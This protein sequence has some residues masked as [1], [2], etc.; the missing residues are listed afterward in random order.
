MFLVYCRCPAVVAFGV[1]LIRMHGSTLTG[2][3]QSIIL[4]VRKYCAHTFTYIR[5][6]V[7]G[8]GYWCLIWMGRLSPAHGPQDSVSAGVLNMG[9]KILHFTSNTWKRGGRFKILHCP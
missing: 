5:G 3:P 2:Q 4:Y 1:V 8:G 7:G 9:I 6:G